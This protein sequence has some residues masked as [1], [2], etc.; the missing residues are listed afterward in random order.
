MNPS[1]FNIKLIKISRISFYINNRIKTFNHFVKTIKELKK[2]QTLIF[3]Y[4]AFAEFK[5]EQLIIING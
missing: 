1:V 5:R 4:W 2:N 3:T